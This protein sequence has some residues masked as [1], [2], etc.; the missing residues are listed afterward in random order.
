MVAQTGALA[1][2]GAF[3]AACGAG[4]APTGVPAGA[5]ASQQGTAEL[6]WL[7]SEDPKT[8]GM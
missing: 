5:P 3:A 1:A 6:T 7:M 4:A 8:S 2:A